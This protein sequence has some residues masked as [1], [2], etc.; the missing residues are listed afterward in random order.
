MA[1]D[2][3]NSRNRDILQNRNIPQKKDI[4]QKKGIPQK[5]ILEKILLAYGD[6]FAD[7]Q[8]ALAYEGQQRLRAEDLIPAPTESFYPGK[9]GMRSQF[10]DV[11]SYLMNEGKIKI[12]YLIGNETGL[13]GRQVLRKASYQGGAYRTQL[14]SGKPVYPI[15]GMVIDW[16]HKGSRIPLSLHELLRRDGVPQEDLDRVDDV[17][18]EVYHMHSLPPEVRRRF[19]SDL[20]FVVDFLNEGSFE[21]RREQP[22][23]HAEALC[24]MMAA[25]TGDTRFTDQMA[26][27]LKKQRERKEIIMCEY[28]DMLEARGEERGIKIGESRGIAIGEE[29]GAVKGENR[30]A[31]LIQL[32]MSEKK[33]KDVEAVSSSRE[34]RHEFY[35]K[36]G[37]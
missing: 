27:L 3:N 11:S 25:L 36:Y 19:T 21:N 35:R 23:I 24:E 10:S 12:Q 30:L 18:L 8:N 1:R 7:C 37:I 5:D 29:Q 4:P 6:V 31:R 14:D 2:K 22:I 34:K 20:G 28:I 32:L 33:Y 26:E 13:E 9:E 15:I 17:R 16:T